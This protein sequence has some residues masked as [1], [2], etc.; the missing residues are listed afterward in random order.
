MPEAKLEDVAVSSSVDEDVWPDVGSGY[1]TGKPVFQAVLKI[2]QMPEVETSVQST[3]RSGRS[4][5]FP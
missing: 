1:V 4:L 2:F 3:T 5:C